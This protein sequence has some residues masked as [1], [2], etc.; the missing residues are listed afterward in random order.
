MVVT[1]QGIQSGAVSSMDGIE[2]QQC[3][4]QRQTSIHRV[5]GRAP[6]TPVETQNGWKN[7]LKPMKV[8]SG[9]GPLN[10]AQLVKRQTVPAS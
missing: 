8:G 7:H 6:V 1:D 5:A 3:V 2:M 9:G 4:A 10:P